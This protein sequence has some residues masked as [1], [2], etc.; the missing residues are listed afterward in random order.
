MKRLIIPLIT[1]CLVSASFGQSFI[2]R[3]M[4]LDTNG[5]DK[6]SKQ[7]MPERMRS[8]FDD[9]DS[10]GDGFVDRKEIV[11]LARQMMQSA[12]PQT[13]ISEEITV[14][15]DIAYREGHDRWKLDLY[16]PKSE[17][18]EGGRPAIVCIHGGGWKMGDKASGNCVKVANSYAAKGYVAISI[19]YRLLP[20]A[21]MMDCIADAKTAVR[22]LRANAEKYGVDPDRIGGFG[23]SAGAHLVSMLALSADEKALD[24]EDAPYS[25]FSSQIQAAVPAAAPTDFLFWKGVKGDSERFNLIV[26]G[27][28]TAE[29]NVVAASPVTYVSEDAPPFLLIHAKDDRVVPFFQGESL[30]GKLKA[31]G[32]DVE[33]L[34]FETGG[35]GVLNTQKNAVTPAMEKFFKRTL[36][37]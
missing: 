35:H 6:L 17:A 30:T 15:R 5:D 18:P 33:L 8:Y 2:D 10:D 3:V 13:E 24:G 1:S 31:A 23:N 4:L 26:K 20:E 32:G 21:G 16:L 28:G 19:N 37:L 14:Q 29:E 11:G 36:G 22:W 7:E 12:G 9:V 34:S 25:E 27:P